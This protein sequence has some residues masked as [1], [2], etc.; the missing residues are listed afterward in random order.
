MRIPP[1]GELRLGQT[2]RFSEGHTRS[3]HESA[4]LLAKG[5]PAMP[6]DP[7]SDVLEWA[8]TG[9]KLHP[10]QKPVSGLVPLIH[11]Y[12]KPNDLIIDPFAGSGTTGVAARH[13]NR[14][15]LLIEQDAG[16][17]Q[18]A[19]ERLKQEVPARLN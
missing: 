6:K 12:T 4:Y 10:T 13:C 11:A 7:P 14:H 18:T 17:Y 5:Y 15:Y 8:Y 3:K 16:Y 1:R 2:L 19:V 9:N